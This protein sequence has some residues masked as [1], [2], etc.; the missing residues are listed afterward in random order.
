MRSYYKDVSLRLSAVKKI[1]QVLEELIRS[2]SR[3]AGK[4]VFIFTNDDYLL[5]INR[6]FL[7]HDYYTD[8][9]TFDYSSDNILSGEIYISVDRVKENALNYEV[10]YQ[11]EVTRVMIHSVLHLCGYKDE[12]DEE[13]RIMRSLEDLWLERINL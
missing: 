6:E 8:V 7:K 10:S 12:K 9:I 5:Q 1:Y 11:D 2:E 13:K 4:I 3:I